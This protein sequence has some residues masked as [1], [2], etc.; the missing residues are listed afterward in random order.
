MTTIEELIC[1][2]HN[3]AERADF[4]TCPI[5]LWHIHKHACAE[6]DALTARVK[7][8]ESRPATTKE[9]SL[10][11]AIEGNRAGMAHTD[12]VLTCNMLERGRAVWRKEAEEAQQRVRELESTSGCAYAGPSRGDCAHFIGLPGKSI[13]GQHDGTD[14]TVDCY[15]KPN[16]WCWHCWKDHK[17]EKA[18]GRVKEL[19][20]ESDQK[21]L[22]AAKFCSELQYERQRIKELEAD[23]ARLIT[24]LNLS[25]LDAERKQP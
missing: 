6:R 3:D 8:L 2:H 7:E 19:E 9:D 4:K 13:P 22:L 10:V 14:D 23:N 1:V 5:C 11:A 12:L 24:Q 25:N 15:G 16:G 17:L 20:A 18:I 21:A